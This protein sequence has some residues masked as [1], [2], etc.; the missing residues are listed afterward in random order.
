MVSATLGGGAI[1][2]RALKVPTNFDYLEY[3]SLSF[4][5]GVGVIGWGVFFLGAL[6]S[7]SQLSFILFLGFLIFGIY[8]FKP[9]SF[10]FT[11]FEKLDKWG[12]LLLIGIGLILVYDFME[13]VAPPSDADSLAYHFSLP[14][15]FLRAGGLFPVFQAVEG[16][17]PLL[18]QMTY[19]VAL[20][21]GGEKL[22]T[23]WTMVSGF[24]AGLMV[25]VISKRYLSINWSLSICLVFISTPAV[26]YGAGSGQVEVRN[27]AFVLVAAFGLIEA[28][29]T[30]LFRYTILAG[31][32]AGLFVASKYTGLIF[33]FSV[34]MLFLGQKRWLAHSLI[35]A[36]SVLVIGGQWY[37]WNAWNT[38]DPIYP[39]LFG[40]VPYLDLVPWNEQINSHF[41]I[42]MQ[43]KVVATNFFWFV[44]YPIKAVLTSDPIFGPLRTGYGLLIVLLLPFAILAVVTKKNYKFNHSLVKIS[45]VCLIFY[46]IWFFFGTSQRIRHLFPLYP[47]LLLIFCIAS[48][49][50]IEVMPSIKFA[51]YGVFVLVISIQLIGSTVFALNYARF[52][53]TNEDRETFLR[54]NVS[55]YDVVLPVLKKLG[56]DYRLLL[57]TRQLVYFFRSAFYANP[58]DQ[59]TIETRKK[60]VEPLLLWRQMRNQA[61]T[62]ILLPFELNNKNH[63][64]LNFKKNV[65]SLQRKSCLILVGQ[66]SGT[67]I[68]SRTLPIW[69]GEK[70]KFTLLKLTPKACS[71]SYV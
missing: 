37:A 40:K 57:E 9:L 18:Q 63:L 66:F 16:A 42:I 27:A 23:L 62:H 21:I 50:L 8:F 55:Q 29:R 35:F 28:L 3:M 5:I 39:L 15:E 70:A 4:V 12:W 44:F 26:I 19:M 53:L 61:I 1:F 10:K 45:I 48:V 7:V 69:S 13:G 14:K 31:I 71:F 24:G 65:L 6:G 68:V 2:L 60:F 20:E 34:G 56:P 49:R 58:N 36:I 43:E 38:G 41:K 54:R 33:A 59:A 46:S 64:D 67:S 22:L 11:T 52:V 51:L 30:N 25:F 17:I 47:L 32:G